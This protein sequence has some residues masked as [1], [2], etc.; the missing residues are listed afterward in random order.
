MKHY[1][2]TECI[3]VKQNFFVCPKCHPEIVTLSNGKKF[4]AWEYKISM[5]H[6]NRAHLRSKTFQGIADAMAKQWGDCKSLQLCI[7]S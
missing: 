1:C 5:N 2:G 7:E 6:K 3:E 4:S